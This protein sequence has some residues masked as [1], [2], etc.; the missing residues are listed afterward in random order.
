[1]EYTFKEQPKEKKTFS[2]ENPRPVVDDGQYLCRIIHV[3]KVDYAEEVKNEKGEIVE[4][5]GLRFTLVPVDREHED[6]R[7]KD[8]IHLWHH[9]ETARASADRKLKM[10]CDFAGLPVSRGINFDEL[11]GRRVGVTVER[12]SRFDDE[13]KR[14][15]FNEVKRWHA[16]PDKQA[17]NFPQKSSPTNRAD[18][19]SGN[20]SFD[21]L[22]G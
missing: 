20:Q 2:A 13:G 3:G 7:I 6:V 15:E 11:V 21:S 14:I 16:G 9:K 22:F 19:P 18:A 17:Q 1:M 8:K 5:A 4:N 10:I 12:V